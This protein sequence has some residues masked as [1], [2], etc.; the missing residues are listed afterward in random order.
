[1]GLPGPAARLLEDFSA[2]DDLPVAMSLVS[3]DGRLLRANAAMCRLLGR[4]EPELLGADLGAVTGAEQSVTT[5][6][7]ELTTGRSDVVTVPDRYVRRDGTSHDVVVRRTGVRD[8]QGTVALVVEHATC[9]AGDEAERVL[10]TAAVRTAALLRLAERLSA[11][12]R[13][14]AAVADATADA[15]HAALG[16]G[17][18]VFFVDPAD[19]ATL[20][21]ASVRT[22]DPASEAELR[23]LYALRPLRTDVG[24]FG[25]GCAAGRPTVLRDPW[26]ASDP[27]P[28]MDEYTS[29]LA[30]HPVRYLLLVPLQWDGRVL[31][32]VAVGRHGDR[33]F[34]DDDVA[35]ASLVAAQVSRVLADVLLLALER[36][37][38][39]RE[40]A[41]VEVTRRCDE[42]LGNPSD[43][44]D[45][46]VRAVAAEVGAACAAWLLHEA[47]DGVQ[48]GRAAV[49]HPDPAV[50][51]LLQPW[52]RN[53]VHEGATF[54]PRVLREGR[55]YVVGR[56]EVAALAAGVASLQGCAD[57]VAVASL[58]GVRLAAR[59][60][61][62]GLLLVGSRS[63]PL[64]TDD[65]RLVDALAERVALALDNA[66]LLGAAR[67]SRSRA[68]AL[69]E[70]CSDLLLMADAEGAI[71]YASPA[72]AR[73][74]GRRLG[75]TLMASVVPDDQGVVA[76]SWRAA[77]EQPGLSAPVDVRVRDV[78]GRLRR[79]SAVMNNLLHDPAVGGVVLTVRDVTEERAAT[80]RLAARAGQQAA[81]AAIGAT[82][83]TAGLDELYM[84]VAKS[85]GEVLD[86]RDTGVLQRIGD[87]SWV[88]LGCN[89]P[90]HVGTTLEVGKRAGLSVLAGTARPVLVEDYA[91]PGLIDE[92][93]VVQEYGVR[94]GALA[95]VLVNGEVWGAV[96][97]TA[98]APG[99]F[100]DVDADFMQTVAAVLAGAVERDE[101]A[102]RVLA[103]AT[104]DD[105]TGLPNRAGVH[106]TLAQALRNRRATGEPVALL[107]LDVDDFKD[108]NDSLGHGAG[109]EVLIQ[110]GRRLTEVVGR[111]AHV[112]R[113][114]G[115]EFAVVLDGCGA[116][117]AADVAQDLAR[118]VGEPFALRGIDVTLSTSTGIA[119]APDHGA[120]VEHLLQ[121]A[122]MAMYRAKTERSGSA[123]YDAVLDSRRSE[124]LA[125]L[126][127]LRVALS[128]GQL[129]LHYQPLVDLA[130]GRVVEVE[131]LLRWQHPERGLLLPGEFLP[132][133]E[134]TDLVHG[135]TRHV[136]R[137][138]ARQ[139]R[140]WRAA[141]WPGTVAVNVSALALRPP[142]VVDALREELLRGEGALSVEL[143]ESALAD[144][145]AREAIATLAAAGIACSIDD[146]GT[147]WSSLS[148]LRDLP[149]SRLK[150]DR[151]F[152]RRVD[153]DERDAAIVGGVV[154]MAHAIGLDVVAE[155]VE[156]PEVAGRL[157]ELGVDVAQ[158]WLYGR[159]QPAC[160]LR[161]A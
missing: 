157:R 51:D 145:R 87:H 107:L 40:R 25:T 65:R 131:A 79:V 148:Y 73:I 129:V 62:V 31:G 152:N 102:S 60:Q 130:S 143:T 114:G 78:D 64:S 137:T 35:F 48:V 76:R 153:R 20:E 155:G 100:T 89:E 158:G 3:C 55:A 117:T 52:L 84:T 140:E 85:I 53:W 19:A 127:E 126:S 112:A 15:V 125:L 43:V 11:S 83:L 92:T 33:S 2:F 138:A 86:A 24:V 45:A 136:V 156:T 139:A 54:L 90:N 30:A 121:A 97:A 6:L 59:G 4:T 124:R 61:T 10:A 123:V 72:A 14:P 18:S 142:D 9:G 160:E 99:C 113:L 50:E 80:E 63:R 22:G 38:A 36:S 46:A 81:L 32:L 108:V 5:S 42:A 120:A 103:Q 133:A 28:V 13:G 88:V 118:C 110:L 1:M 66:A 57:D 151:S 101:I 161:L 106:Q 41:V 16:G 23:R 116:E 49:T 111:R 75:E 154:T 119:V 58:Y 122:D 150:L 104:T 34:C 77:L 70:H 21:A 91:R 68:R 146:F 37:T 93:S 96:T 141:G 82:A 134:Q 147:G 74:F 98:E 67:S 47:P 135:L 132:T 128:S 71:T 69:V 29:W 12:H 144:D 26:G 95:P 39:R 27:S 115:D 7:S 94:S 149:V 109:D 44:L 56:D 17:V 159:P 8:A 105:L